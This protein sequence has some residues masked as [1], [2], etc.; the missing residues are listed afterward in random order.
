[1]KRVFFLAAFHLAMVGML[2]A[3]GTTDVYYRIEKLIYKQRYADAYQVSDSLR[4]DAM[5]RVKAGQVDPMVSRQLLTATWYMERAAI[6]YQED[7]VDSSMARFRAILPYLTPEDRCLCRLFLGNIDSAL[8]DTLSLRDIPNS[9]IAAFCTAP[10]DVRF[11]TT[12]TMYDLVMQLAIMNVPLKRKIELQRQLTEWYRSRPTKENINLTLYNELALLDYLTDQPNKT[13]AYRKHLTQECLNRYRWTGNEQLALLYDDLAGY[14]ELDSDYVGA[15]VYCDSAI[16]RWP[17]SRGGVDCANRKREIQMVKIETEIASASPA[18]RDILMTIKTR[19]VENLYYRV[20]AYP[21]WYKNCYENDAKIRTRLMKE[22]VLKSWS[23]TFTLPKDYKYYSHYGYVP[24]LSPGRYML[25]V[26]PTK[27]FTGHGFCVQSFTV[28]AAVFVLMSSVQDSLSGYVVDY[29]TGEPIARQQVQV[30]RYK[31]YSDEKYTTVATAVTDAK[32]FFSTFV[33]KE[34][35]D[36]YYYDY[37]LLTRYKGL[38]VTAEQSLWSGMKDTGRFVNKIILDRPVYRPGDTLQFML[39]EGRVV[40]NRDGRAVVGDRVMVDLRDVN[41]KTIDTLLG[42]TDAYGSLSGTFV[43]PANALPGYF[44]IWA[45]STKTNNRVIRKGFPVEAYKQ[46]KFTVTLNGVDRKDAE[47]HSIAPALGDSLV[48][49]GL[50][51][52]Y[53]QVPVSGAKVVY[54]VTRTQMHPWWRRWYWDMPVSEAAVL[55]S[56]SLVTDAEGQFRIAFVAEPDSNIELSTKPCFTYEVRVDVTDI[57]GETHSQSHALNAGYENSYITLS[58]P[59][60]VTELNSVEYKY[61]DLNGTPLK[62]NVTL[63]I[64][65]LREPDSPW[66]SHGQIRPGV[67]HTISKEEFHK[68]FPLTPYNYEE[69]KMSNWPVEKRVYDT[70]LR[71]EGL[72]GNKVPLPVLEAGVYRVRVALDGTS[73]QQVGDEAVVVY[74]PRTSSRVHCMDLLWSDISATE[75]RV[76]DTVVLRF[77]SRHKNVQVAYELMCDDKRLERRLLRVDNSISMLRI[78]VSETM[79]GGFDISLCAVQEGR[80][81]ELTYHVAVPFVH[82]KLD[83]QIVTFRDKLTP[84]EKEQWTIKV[85]P[86]HEADGSIPTAALLLGMYDAALDNYG[87]GGNSFTWLPW[88]SNDSR[89]APGMT[90]AIPWHY[91]AYNDLLIDGRI[92]RYEGKEPGGWIFSALNH[93]GWQ[94]RRSMSKSKMVMPGTSI[95]SVGGIGYS[96]DAATARGESGM[97][98]MSANARKRAAAKSYESEELVAEMAVI[99]DIVVVENDVEM[100]ESAFSSSKSS[101]VSGAEKPYIRTNLS[102]LAFFEPTL[103]TDKDGTVSYSFTAPDLLTQWNVKGL[104]WTPE[105]ATGQLERQLITRKELM[106]QPNMPRFLREGDTATLMAKVMNLTDS[107]LTVK[108]DFSFIIA[109]GASR[110]EN[111]PGAAANSQFSILNSQLITV[112]AH[113]TVPVLFPVT[114]PVG[115]TVATYK[116]VATATHHSDAEQGPLPLLTNRQAVTQSVSMYMNGKGTKQYTMRIPTSTTAQPVSFSVEYTA[117]PIWL[118]IQSLPFMSECSNPSNIYLFNSYYVNTVGKTIADQYPELKHCAVGAIEENSPLFRNSDIRQTLLDETPWLRSGT[119]EVERLKNIA[120][121]YDPE[122]LQRQCSE[123]VSKLQKAQRGDGGWSWM[124]DGRYSSTYVTQYILKGLGNMQDAPSRIKNRALAYVDKEAY[125][126]Y[127]DWMKYLQKHPNSQCKPIM[128]DYLYTRSYYTDKKLTAD[129]QKAFDYFYGNAKQRYSDYTS[130]YDQALLALVFHRH[131]DTKLAKEMVER[132]RQKALYSD[133]MGMYWRDNRAGY[134]YYQ[135]PVETQALLIETFREVLPADTLSVAQM[136]QWLLKQKQTTRWSSD[137]ATLRAIQSL[138]P[139]ETKNDKLKTKMEDAVVVRGK[140][141]TDTLHI[142][143][144]D[145]SAGYLRHT[146]RGDSLARLTNSNS[147]SATIV[148]PNK[149]ISWGALYYQYTEQMDKVPASETGITLERMLY[150]IEAD[151]SL[152]ELKNGVN[153]SVGD[154]LRVRLNVSCDR[155]LEYVE[156]KEFR[157]ACLEPV[158]TASGWVWGWGLSYYVAVNNSH[159]AVYI[160]RM[161]KGKYTIDVDYYVTN[162]GTFTLAPSVLQ[163]LY[164]PEFRATSRGQRITV[165]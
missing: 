76:G 72:N 121:F 145:G 52:S 27:D 106:V 149:G 80:T 102:T 147:V 68:R 29:V 120:H 93:R 124:P 126:D 152:T 25:L 43:I 74:T 71:C 113:G 85:S 33:K 94:W 54:S 13:T 110:I 132:I 78:P 136:Q 162:P 63:T 14:S 90:I 28:S 35:K 19:N 100:E 165:K 119:S 133:E 49:E 156:L 150:R 4:A 59:E 22:R 125:K 104:A 88:L 2:S 116:Y 91:C 55:V 7:V 134:F 11:N 60:Q 141:L 83:V 66:L 140:A 99:N 135:R 146:Y 23:Q 158:S 62:G 8:V 107:D 101:K 48:V 143:V 42:V 114:V 21:E 127:L 159:N 65:R 45:Y 129:H 46:P 41:S 163:C 32:G 108:V 64:E 97:V 12:P 53:T 142:A 56:D 109:N 69:E 6:N 30:Q 112:P 86:K 95:V 16:G 50:A 128:L 15:V 131:G 51:A 157:A 31:K 122:E 103:R 17:K 111:H 151:G 87:Y 164:A 96:D 39:V 57:N 3:Q 40:N 148:R 160:D 70:R 84:G 138:M 139:V 77:G 47:G 37:R 98:T 73:G 36:Y 34:R 117:N 144:A 67:R 9:Q 61:C 18:G 44:N 137:I 10:K 105:L 123:T 153:I 38:D 154:R 115:G 89:Y 161:E 81:S 26:S 82:K 58:L 75:A 5:S 130:L 1:M 24:Q 20:I 92:Y 118:A 79:L 155:A